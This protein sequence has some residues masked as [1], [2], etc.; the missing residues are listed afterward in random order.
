MGQ[1]VFYITERAVFELTEQG[2]SLVEIA[3]GV[4]LEKDVLAQ[5]DCVPIIGDVKPM[6]VRLFNEEKWE[7]GKGETFMR[8]AVIVSAGLMKNAAGTYGLLALLYLLE[9]QELL[10]L[11]V[12]PNLQ[13]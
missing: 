6:D 7:I 3:P 4:D 8:E 1:K 2:V 12:T 11:W 9:Q 5:M 10:C 13:L